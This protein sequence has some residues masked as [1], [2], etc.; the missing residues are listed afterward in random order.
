MGEG[1][2]KKRID[3]YRE[4]IMYLFFGV[5]T[6]LLNMV[7]YYVFDKK[8]NLGNSSNVVLSNII[9]I[10][11]AYIT[12]RTWVFEQKAHGAK[13]IKKE[14]ISFFSCRIGTLLLDW[15]FMFLTVDILLQNG[16]IMKFISNVIVVIVNYVASKIVVFGKR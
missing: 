6:T 12:N 3:N 7:L 16:N 11:F 4:V 10:L 13:E 8:L 5:C 14:I 1:E 9:C 2:L 15:A